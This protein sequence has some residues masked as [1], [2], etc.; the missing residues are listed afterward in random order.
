M[1]LNKTKD[2]KLKRLSNNTSSS[3]LNVNKLIKKKS[4]VKGGASKMSETNLRR[5]NLDAQNDAADADDDD[6]SSE[7]EVDD[8]QQKIK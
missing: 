1:T 8:G 7:N 6:S 5:K 2:K 4:I 3:T